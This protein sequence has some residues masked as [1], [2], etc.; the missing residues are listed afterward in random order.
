MDLSKEL[1]YKSLLGINGYI[2]IHL[3]VA[4]YFTVRYPVKDSTDFIWMV[5]RDIY[6]VGGDQTIEIKHVL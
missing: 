2:V 4:T 1:R 3:M 6:R 5:H